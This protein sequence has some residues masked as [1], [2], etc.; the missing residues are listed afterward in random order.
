MSISLALKGVAS[1]TA[2]DLRLKELPYALRRL[3]RVRATDYMKPA[4]PIYVARVAAIEREIVAWE[5]LANGIGL[6]NK[7]E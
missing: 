3:E 4:I 5:N 6:L 2:K 1:A 7:G